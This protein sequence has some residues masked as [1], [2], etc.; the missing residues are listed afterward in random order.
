[1]SDPHAPSPVTGILESSLYVESLER[2]REFYQSLF[3]FEQLFA[4]ARLCALGVAGRQVLLLFTKGGSDHA[5]VVPGGVPA[6]HV[7]DM[8]P[9]TL[10][11]AGFLGGI[12]FAL[13][14]GVLGG[15]R[16]FHEFSHGQFIGFGTLSGALLGVFLMVALGAPLAFAAL[17]TALSAVGGS[18]TLAV[19]RVAER[20]GLI[21]RGADPELGDGDAPGLLR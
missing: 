14:L 16:R 4:D 1:M 9:Q 12:L 21:G 8:W 19:A 2:S 5:N 10:A 6:V 13:V 7:V 17:V 20:R 15:R 11:I 3:G 18:A